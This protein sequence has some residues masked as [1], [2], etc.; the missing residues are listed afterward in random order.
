MLKENIIMEYQKRYL[1][2]DS[3]L[4]RTKELK[5]ILPMCFLF[6]RATLAHNIEN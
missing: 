6:L 3:D 1:K 5:R 4:Y 2:M